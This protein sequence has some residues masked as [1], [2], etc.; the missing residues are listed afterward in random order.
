MVQRFLHVVTQGECSDQESARRVALAV[1]ESPLLSLRNEAGHFS[2]CP[3]V[4][5]QVHALVTG[6]EQPL[7]RGD[8]DRADR[9]VDVM[10]FRGHDRR[11]PEFAKVNIAGGNVDPEQSLVDAIPH[12]ALRELVALGGGAV[13]RVFFHRGLL[14]LLGPRPGW[15]RDD[16]SGAPPVLGVSER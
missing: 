15:I 2:R 7:V 13:R 3:I 9:A 8:C 6:D 11:A 16:R 14:S 4:G 12:R 5:N 10:G 1:V